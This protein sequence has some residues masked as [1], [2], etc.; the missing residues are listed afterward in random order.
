MAK[1][2]SSRMDNLEPYQLQ[3]DLEQ[4][5]FYVYFNN[6]NRI[7]INELISER[8]EVHWKERKIIDSILEWLQRQHPET[9][10]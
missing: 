10:I 5:K 4:K 8:N 3:Y 6:G 9:L 1:G 2:E 7:S